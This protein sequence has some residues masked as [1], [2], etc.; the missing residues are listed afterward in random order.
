MKGPNGSSAASRSIDSKCWN[1][2]G[3][4]YV[5]LFSVIGGG[6][7]IPQ[8]VYMFPRILGK[9]VRELNSIEQAIEFFHL[10]YPR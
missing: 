7:V 6:H 1:K 10:K 4:A 8:P 3:D 2:S 5:E 9:T